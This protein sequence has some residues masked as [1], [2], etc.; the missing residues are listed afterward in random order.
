MTRTWIFATAAMSL[1]NLQAIA[2]EKMVE[3]DRAALED[4]NEVAALYGDI[5]KAAKQACRE[6][7]ASPY[8]QSGSLKACQRE[9]VARA[10]A[11][12]GS[13]MLTQYAD[14]SEAKI[15]ASTE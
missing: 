4:P 8:Y 11:D 3:F 10:V 15:I 12:V 5:E 2:A 7:Y 13:P 14:E 9:A 6:E 1:I